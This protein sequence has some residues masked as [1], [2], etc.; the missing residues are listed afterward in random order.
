MT[1]APCSPCWVKASPGVL[2]SALS[3]LVRN[4]VKYMGDA[5]ER[6]IEVRVFAQGAMTRFEVAD[7][8]PGIPANLLDSIFEPYVRA[9]PAAAKGI[10][11]GLATVKRVV[12]TH[13]GRVGVQS[14]LGA[15]SL[16]WFELPAATPP[17]PLAS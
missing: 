16:F 3:N 2:T 5:P 9:N 4:A 14:A 7:T 10:G 17:D 12:V 6:R 15:G 1:S 13:G 11:L 8:G